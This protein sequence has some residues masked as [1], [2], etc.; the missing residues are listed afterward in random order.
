MFLNYS[1]DINV[2]ILF[3]TLRRGKTTLF[4]TP[5]LLSDVISYLRAMKFISGT[6]II[7]HVLLSEGV[8]FVEG[9]EFAEAKQQL[10]SAEKLH[11]QTRIQLSNMRP[12]AV[13]RVGRSALNTINNQAN[14]TC[15]VAV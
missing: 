12:L 14:L 9:V 7:F 15:C 1:R 8:E 13:I 10:A 5:I 4:S 3:I 6:P 2:F 11:E